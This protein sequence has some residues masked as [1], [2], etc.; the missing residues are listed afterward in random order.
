MQ[1]KQKNKVK[2]YGISAVVTVSAELGLHGQMG[3]YLIILF[4]KINSRK[5]EEAL[6]GVVH[7]KMKIQSS[8]T[9]PHADG[10]IGKGF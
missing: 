4:V 1:K 7:P 9:H 5:K 6:K 8:F 10:R 2:Q 3:R